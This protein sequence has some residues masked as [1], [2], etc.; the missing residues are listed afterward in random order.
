MVKS[1]RCS[2]PLVELAAEVERLGAVVLLQHRVRYITAVPGSAVAQAAEDDRAVVGTY[3]EGV[4]P[5]WIAADIA[6]GAL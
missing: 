3:V 2:H 6:E 5:E 1:E 4:H